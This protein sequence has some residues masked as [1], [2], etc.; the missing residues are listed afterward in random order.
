M[1]YALYTTEGVFLD[2]NINSI[3]N[4]IIDTLINE[5]DQATV[6]A[7]FAVTG[8]VAKIIQGASKIDV[9]GDPVKVKVIPFVID[10][11]AMYDFLKGIIG[12]LLSNRGVINYTDRFQVLG[13]RVYIEVWW[14]AAA[15]NMIDSNG[16]FSENKNNI[17]NYIL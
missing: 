16:I 10:D 17:P 2:N 7:H 9:N 11:Q 13:T 5:Y 6:D 4:L 12:T 8:T 15:I 1:A 14:R 3:C